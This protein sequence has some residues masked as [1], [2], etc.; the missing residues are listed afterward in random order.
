[1]DI[2]NAMEKWV[3]LGYKL[4]ETEIDGKF[5]IQF[6][7]DEEMVGWIKATSGGIRWNYPDELFDK[8]NV[9]EWVGEI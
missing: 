7:K 5:T 6:L 8:P 3:T 1:M 9:K 4:N 2:I